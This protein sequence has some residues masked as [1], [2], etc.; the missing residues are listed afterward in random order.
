MIAS[1]TTCTHTV[2]TSSME[3]FLITYNS[4]RN[5]LRPTSV[6]LQE[7]G[8][9]LS[10]VL[11]SWSL[12]ALAKSLSFSLSAIPHSGVCVCVLCVVCAYE[13]TAVLV[14]VAFI[15]T[16]AIPSYTPIATYMLNKPYPSYIGIS[17]LAR[18]T[19]HFA[20][21]WSQKGYSTM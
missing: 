18:C 8:C 11:T 12:S 6:K 2:K 16:L 20:Q 17:P 21:I 10:C 9:L 1:K 19:L 4:A 7:M 3:Y 13:E 15:S 14:V 5:G